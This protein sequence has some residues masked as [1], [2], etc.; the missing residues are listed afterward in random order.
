MARNCKSAAMSLTVKHRDNTKLYTTHAKKKMTPATQKDP[1]LL[2]MVWNLHKESSLLQCSFSRS[3]ID[4]PCIWGDRMFG[5]SHVLRET[6][7]LCQNT[8]RKLTL[9]VL[10]D[11]QTMWHH[12]MIFKGTM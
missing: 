3:G 10:H 8:L 1:I 5:A 6:T 2:G 4:H 11:L 9:K 12:W 7:L